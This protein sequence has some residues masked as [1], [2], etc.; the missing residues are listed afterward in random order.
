MPQAA[1]GAGIELCWESTGEGRPLVLCMGIAAQLI[2]WPEGF[3][4]LLADRGFRVIRFDNRD[5]GRSS[6]LDHLGRPSWGRLAWAL[7]RRRRAQAPYTLWD[8]AE[9]TRGLLDVLGLER[10][11]MAGM[12]MGGMI[13]QCLALTH[14]Q[15]LLSLTS[16]SSSTGSRQEPMGRPGVLWAAM[17]PRSG[18]RE[19]AIAHEVKLLRALGSPRTPTPV[20]D[21]RALAE[22]S[23]ERGHH[24]EGVL[25][26]AAAIVASGSRRRRLAALALPTL[27][28]HGEDDPLIP[29]GCGRFTAAAIPGARLQTLPGWGHDLPRAHW[30]TL[31]DAI[32]AHAMAAEA[33]P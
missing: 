31:V 32:A 4:R 28:L 19:G 23:W 3:V 8:M 5:V 24:P 16:I 15:R 7:A 25:R 21:L 9:D 1:V 30:P 29:V 22:A 12:S 27:V 33:A 20:E 10:V 6:W 13:A 17:G 2:H 26:Q 14:P 18:E 11:H